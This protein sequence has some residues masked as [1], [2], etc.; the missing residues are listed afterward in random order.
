[1]IAEQIPTKLAP[2]TLKNTNLKIVH[3]TVARE[4]REAVG[5]A[6]NM[7]DDQ[8]EYLSSLRRG[9]AAVYAEGDS[10]PKCVKFLMEPFYDYERKKSSAKSGKKFMI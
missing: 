3:R 5:K 2:D 7:S 6:M 10:R 1:M 8:M 4:D 9:Y